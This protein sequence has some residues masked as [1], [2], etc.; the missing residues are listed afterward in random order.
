VINLLLMGVL[1]DAVFQWIILGVSHAGAAIVVGPVLVLGPYA[2]ARGL[3]NR[4][5]RRSAHPSV[6]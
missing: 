5:A 3:A 2:I 1:L 4:L 6:R